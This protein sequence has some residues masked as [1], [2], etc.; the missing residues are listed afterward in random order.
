[1]SVVPQVSTNNKSVSSL[2]PPKLPPVAND[3]DQEDEGREVEEEIAR[4]KEEIAR[5]KEEITR[6]ER[7]KT[8]LEKIQRRPQNVS[9]TRQRRHARAAKKL[10]QQERKRREE[11]VKKLAEEEAEAKR[12]AEEAEAKRLAEEADAK[13]L[14]EEAD[15][16]RLDTMEAEPEPQLLV[17]VT[18]PA[19]NN[20]ERKVELVL[21]K[22]GNVIEA[23]SAFCREHCQGLDSESLFAFQ[24]KLCQF[25]QKQIST[26][27]KGLP[28]DRAIPRT[29]G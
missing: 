4:I 20:I 2:S 14:A 23:I 16:K 1:M 11:E 26:L 25:A 15:A 7:R 17:Q 28:L 22:G 9:R 24:T 12:L 27:E 19:I 29:G 13:R 6:L 10:V 5:H 18:I 21:Y 3:S 8:E